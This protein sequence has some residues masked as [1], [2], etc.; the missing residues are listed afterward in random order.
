MR[1]DPPEHENGDMYL[2]IL[3][4]F[5]FIAGLVAL[6]IIAYNKAGG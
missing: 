6:V 3:L 5:I 2:L 1:N 4:S